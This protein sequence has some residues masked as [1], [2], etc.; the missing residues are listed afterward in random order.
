MHVM[1]SAKSVTDP[2]D[3]SAVQHAP[4]PSSALALEESLA[5]LLLHLALDP[6]ICL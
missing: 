3:S 1:P 5:E 6:V 4:A 2:L